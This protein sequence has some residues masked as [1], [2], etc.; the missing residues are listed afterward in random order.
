[1]EQ[2]TKS[3][4]GYQSIAANYIAAPDPIDARSMQ[5]WWKD[6]DKVAEIQT[7]EGEA[8]KGSASEFVSS[9]RCT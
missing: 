9:P 1:M 5:Q 2:G 7:K 3:R 8:E 6:K 4:K